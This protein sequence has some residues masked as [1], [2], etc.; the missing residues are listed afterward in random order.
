MLMKMTSLLYLIPEHNSSVNCVDLSEH[1]AVL[2]GKL[3]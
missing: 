3:L 1:D 2:T